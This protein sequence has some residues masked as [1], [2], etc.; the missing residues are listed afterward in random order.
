MT[1]FDLP[2][3]STAERKIATAFRRK[4]IKDGYVMLQFSVYIRHCGSPALAKVHLHRLQGMVPDKGKVSSLLITDVQ[5]GAMTNY[6]GKR[7]QKPA[8]GA[9]P[10][11]ELF[12]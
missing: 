5:Y 7:R 6:F 11:L 3:V 10:Q 4:L 2:V 12:L 1:M 8:H 9:L